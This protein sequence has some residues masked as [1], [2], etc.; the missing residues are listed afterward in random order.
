MLINNKWMKHWIQF[1]VNVSNCIWWINF[2]FSTITWITIENIFEYENREI[3]L[4]V[5][6]RGYEKVVIRINEK[7]EG[8][9]IILKFDEQVDIERRIKEK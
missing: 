2:V 3:E 5:M 6:F 9:K 7:W 4:K 1:K 8:R